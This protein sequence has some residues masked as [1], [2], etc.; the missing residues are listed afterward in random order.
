MQGSGDLPE[1]TFVAVAGEDVVGY[2]KFSLTKAQPTTAHH[3]LTAVARAWRRK[4]IAAA[5]KRAQVAWAKE[6]GYERAG[7]RTGGS[8]RAQPAHEPELGYRPAPGKVTMRSP[9]AQ[10]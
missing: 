2:A 8:E 5:L 3:D 4:G 10:P 9:L 1:A 6:H 7:D